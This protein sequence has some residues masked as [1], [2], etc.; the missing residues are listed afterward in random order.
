MG[1]PKTD[2]T[3]L[4]PGDDLNVTVPMDNGWTEAPPV[5]HFH[6]HEGSVVD[7]DPAA[8]RDCLRVPH[9]AIVDRARARAGQPGQLSM[10]AGLEKSLCEGVRTSAPSSTLTKRAE[11]QSGGHPMQRSTD[12]ILTTHAGSL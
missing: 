3:A 7:T 12:R 11:G 4:L 5:R 6:S 1:E 10:F 8:E 2:H 9:Q